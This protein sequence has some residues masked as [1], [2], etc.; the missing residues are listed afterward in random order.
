VFTLA[1]S[2]RIEQFDRV[3]TIGHP[4]GIKFSTSMGFVNGLMKTSDLPE[5]LQAYL[6]NPDTEWIQTDA[7]IAGGSSGGPLLNEQGE[8]VGINTL[9]VGTRTGLAV[10]GRHV[11]ELLKNATENVSSLPVPDSIV[12]IT[13]AVAEIKRGFDLE[14]RQFMQDFQA[15]RSSDDTAKLKQLIRKNN[16]GPACIQ[17][18][19]EL[20]TKHRGQPESVDAIRLSAAILASSPN[21]NSGRHFLD[22]LLK[23]ARADPT[24]IPPSAAVI[25]SLYGLSYSPELD[26]F[27]RSVISGDGEP[28]VK[29][30]A[31]IVLV[32]AM[33]KSQDET[34]NAE[35]IELATAIRDR[36]G[37]E[38]YRGKRIREYLDPLIESQAF[39]I[40]SLAPDIEGKDSEGKEF[41]LSEF[42]GKVVVLDFWADWCPHCRNMYPH[43]RKMIEHLKDQPFVLLGVNGD[44]PERA[45]RAI[46]SGN[47]TWRSWLD[48]PSG[49]IGEKY[50]IESWPTIYVLDK[51]GRIRFKDVRGD[52]LE[53]AVESLLNDVPFLSA[54][55]VV[56]ADADWKYHPVTDTNE[57]AEW[58]QPGFDDSKWTSG[59]GPFGY[60]QAR[61]KLE[62]AESG[63]RPVTMLFRRQFDRPAGDLPAKLL[64]QM[65]YRDGLAV[66][67][68]GKE[69]Y[70][71]ALSAGAKLD[72]GAIT[73][74]GDPQ[75]RGITILIDSSELKPTG[76]CIAVELHQFSKYSAQPLFDLTLGSTPDLSKQLAAAT[77]AQQLEI[78]RLLT[79][80]SGLEGSAE[81]IK[82]MQSHES[83]DLQVRAAVAAA[84]NQ[85]PVTLKEFEDPGD[86]QILARAVAGLN[87]AAWDVVSRD[88]LSDIQYAEALRK[89][90]AACTLLPR[91][92]SEYKELMEG[93][94]NTLGV[95]LYRNRQYDKAVETLNESIKIQGDNPVDAGYLALSV[96]RQGNDSDAERQRV[97]FAGLIA[98]DEW[99]YDKNAGQIR[100]EVDREFAK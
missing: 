68:N 76:N 82:Q 26:Q 16:P 51:E 47:V 34:L 12:L 50:K 20:V 19:Q 93:T 73:R 78:C 56:A 64:M 79:Q 4:D 17:R 28:G 2:S 38:A 30:S 54:Q 7:V 27:L 53:L 70:R 85:L 81:I 21:S 67:L 69:V 97:H 60:D 1:D 55:D 72:S 91:V 43:E 22:E 23:Q 3:F 18:C 6:K 77:S 59:S 87:E 13:K 98:S 88:D 65:R 48:G 37:D 5:Q 89:A 75:A 63:Q 24:L 10:R 62:R 84:M 80:T 31:G 100:Q 40:G 61:T 14:Y 41:R 46:K 86:Q 71:D 52:E 58:Q 25:G 94:T 90:Q 99:K 45:R 39:A 15:A 44:E 36:F 92:S 42:R 9:R 74:S 11:A 96:H 33:V 66:H 8:I 95:A 57:L 35:M 83:A 32:S 49:P 29:G